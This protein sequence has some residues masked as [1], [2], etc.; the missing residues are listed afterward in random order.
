VCVVIEHGKTFSGSQLL[1]QS[2]VGNKFTDSNFPFD[3]NDAWDALSF[4]PTSTNHFTLKIN[5]VLIRQL[6]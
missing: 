6:I 5:A 3:I 1:F 2:K 4:C